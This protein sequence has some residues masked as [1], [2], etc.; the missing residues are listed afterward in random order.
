MRRIAQ[1][2][3]IMMACI[4]VVIGTAATARA[5]PAHFCVLGGGHIGVGFDGRPVCVGGTYDGE[6]IDNVRS[7]PAR[8]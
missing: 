1:A 5:V 4:G 6:P 7:R 8:V 2:A 3:A